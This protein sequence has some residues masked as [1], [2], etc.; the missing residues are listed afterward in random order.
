MFST[1]FLNENHLFQQIINSKSFTCH[2]KLRVYVETFPI[3][4]LANANKIVKTIM[5]KED[6][7]GNKRVYYLYKS[8]KSKVF[9]WSGSSACIVKS[10]NT[11]FRKRMPFPV[12][13]STVIDDLEPGVPN[14]IPICGGHAGVPLDMA[15]FLA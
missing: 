5:K 9:C 1:H 10:E 2:F 6:N 15:Y 4:S 7:S 12:Y 8:Q 13:E 11:S 14:S 3:R